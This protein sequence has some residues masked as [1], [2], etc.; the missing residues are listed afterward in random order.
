MP[1]ILHYHPLAAFCHKVLIALYEN[2]IP[3]KGEIVDFGDAQS[4]VNHLRRWPPGKIPVLEDTARGVT[5]PETSIIIEYLE[6]HYPGPVKLLPQDAETLLEVRLWDRIF[7]LYVAVPMQKVTLDRI[8][9]DDQRDPA[10]LA[11]AKAMLTTVYGLIERQLAGKR[12]AVGDQFSLAD[13]AAAPALFYASI[14]MPFGPEHAGL[15]QYFERLLQRPSFARVL[16]EARP[17]FDLYP[18]KD[19]LPARFLA[20]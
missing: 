9:A 18:F 4:R 15:A 17:F 13:C 5:L 2:G 16:R 12:W 19:K 10:G 6:L 14:V 3:F 7:D 11:D 20:G 8:R 1:L